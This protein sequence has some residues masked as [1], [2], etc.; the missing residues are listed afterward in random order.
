[1]TV[2]KTLLVLLALLIAVLAASCSSAESLSSSEYAEWY[3][4]PKEGSDD[5]EEDLEEL[6]FFSSIG[7]MEKVF[8]E[9]D[10][11]WDSV[12][13]SSGFSV[14]HATFADAIDDI[15]SQFGMAV[16]RFGEDESLIAAILFID[17]DAFDQAELEAWHSLSAKNSALL[18]EAGCEVPEDV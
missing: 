12:E 6:N 13:P 18:L 17:F 1:M 14:F 8:I 11:I 16:E 3:C 4:G 15:V 10:E 7:A 2:R 5:L 9:A